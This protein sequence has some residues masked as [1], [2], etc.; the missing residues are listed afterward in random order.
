MRPFDL[1]PLL[2]PLF[3]IWG[4]GGKEF[5]I[6][7]IPSFVLGPYFALSFNFFL[8]LHEFPICFNTFW[9]ALLIFQE[10]NFL[11]YIP[12]LWVP[13]IQCLVKLDCPRLFC[14]YFNYI[15]SVTILLRSF[16]SSQILG[17]HHFKIFYFIVD[18][19]VLKSF[20]HQL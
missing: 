10:L 19:V 15:V 18:R 9:Y 13:C 2:L 11:S 16:L 20:D 12:S 3:F 4:G 14:F 6:S 17:F 5:L 1:S 8:S 7:L